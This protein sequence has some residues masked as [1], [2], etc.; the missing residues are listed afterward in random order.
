M[1]Y[2]LISDS[3]KAG[4]GNVEEVKKKNKQCTRKGWGWRRSSTCLQLFLAQDL[5]GRHWGSGQ[6]HLLLQVKPQHHQHEAS[7][8]AAG[9]QRGRCHALMHLP[10]L[11]WLPYGHWPRSPARLVMFRQSF[12][13]PSNV[14]LSQNK[15]RRISGRSGVWRNAKFHRRA[16]QW[17]FKLGQFAKHRLPLSNW[18]P[19]ATSIS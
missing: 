3:R 7:F 18:P 2:T 13:L 10:P 4:E 12:N 5:V 9:G 6:E 11:H 1:A 17:V 8:L 14:R 19:I 15:I 16:H